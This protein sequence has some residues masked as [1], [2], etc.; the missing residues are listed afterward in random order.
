MTTKRARMIAILRL[1][2]NTIVKSDRFPSSNINKLAT[3]SINE[4]VILGKDFKLFI[5]HD[6]NGYRY[7]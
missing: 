7:I 3:D 6:L 4:F 2:C 1:P 5:I